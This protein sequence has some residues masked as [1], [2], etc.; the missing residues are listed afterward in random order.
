MADISED[1]ASGLADL[2]AYGQMVL[3]NPDFVERIKSSAPMNAAHPDGFYG[4]AEQ[5]YTDYPF[6]RESKGA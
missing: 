1:V 6:L 4:C 2:E 3:A 5:F